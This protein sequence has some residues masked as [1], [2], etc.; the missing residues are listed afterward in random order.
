MVFL[1]R[2]G[3]SSLLGRRFVDGRLLRSDA[4]FAVYAARDTEHGRAVSVKTPVDPHAS[5]LAD[6]LVH[7]ADVLTRIGAHPHIVALHERTSLPDGRQALVLQGAV[8]ALEHLLTADQRMSVQEAVAD[9][10]KLAGALETV[11]DAGFVHG[12]VR[13]RTVL[14]T[15]TGEPL[16]GAF[17]EA[18]PIDAVAGAWPLHVTSAHTAPE[19]LEGGL[20]TPSSD[21]YGLAS[22]LYELVAGHAAFR[23]YSGESP[24]AVIV[25]VLST[26]VRPINAPGVPLELSDLLTWALS[27]DPAR[28]PPTP[29]WLGEELRRVQSRQGWAHTRPSMA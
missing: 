13:P 22:T 2:G 25:R 8:R 9:G 18:V 15:E 26:P 7:E 21:V 10:I 17:D 16:L 11:H 19:V 12:N 1:S 6:Q 27:A 4:R 29:A 3:Q 5:W 24:A 23:A 20:P 14:L 28:R